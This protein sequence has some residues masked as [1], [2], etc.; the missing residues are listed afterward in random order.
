MQLQEIIRLIADYHAAFIHT[1]VGPGL[2]TEAQVTDLINRGVL[3]ADLATT[4][5]PAPGEVA[6][7]HARVISD[8]YN[9]GVMMGSTPEMRIAAPT[10]TYA[11]FRRRKEPPLTPQ[12]R[13]AREWAQQSAASRITGLGNTIAEDF[14]TMAIEADAAQRKRY[15]QAI[16][17]EIDLNIA[18]RESWRKLGSEI[19]H[20][21]GDWSRDFQRIAATEKQDAMQEGFVSSLIERE[22]DPKNIWVAKVPAPDACPDCIRLHLEG[23]KPRIFRLSTLINNGSNVGR[24]RQQ[25]KAVVGP[26]HPWCGCDL[27]HVPAGW[28][29]DDDGDLVPMELKRS[30]FLEHDLRKAESN[31]TYSA[32][33][34]S[35]GCAVH[36]G[37]PRKVEAIEKIIR[38]TPREIF[39]KTIGVTLITTDHPR[40]QNPMDEHDL[41]YW[42]GNEIRLDVHLPV[43]RLDYTLKHELGHSLNV[44]LMHQ[45]GSVDAVRKWHRKLWRISQQEGFVSGYARTLPIENAAEAT[46]LYLYERKRLMLNWPRT[47]AELHRSYRG[48][49]K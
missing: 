31:L 36:V 42:T 10:L 37:D 19:G 49:W 41:A 35:K 22:G 28:H 40:V 15:Q 6:H 39:D 27:V 8:A 45:M 32:I 25:W 11:A 2:I 20:K 46:R 30:Q 34:P 48:I 26:V 24:K 7:S 1:Q 29:F 17:E 12:E 18:K 44:Y 16:R 21:T 13:A 14:S 43:E 47:F 3:P 33:V 5:K 4:F 38:E 9:Y 23:G